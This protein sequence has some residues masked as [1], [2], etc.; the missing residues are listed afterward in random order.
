MGAGAARCAMSLPGFQAYASLSGP[1]MPLSSTIMMSL[2]ILHMRGR[3][4]QPAWE[5]GACSVAAMLMPGY[6]F[7]AAWRAWGLLEMLSAF[8]TAP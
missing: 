5:P 3:E 8:T 1:D 2:R 6:Q 4:R 7:A